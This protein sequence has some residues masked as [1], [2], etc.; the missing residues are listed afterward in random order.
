MENFNASTAVAVD[1]PLHPN[2]IGEL[3]EL[4]A[5]LGVIEGLIRSHIKLQESQ[6]RENI[7]SLFAGNTAL[8]TDKSSQWIGFTHKDIKFRLS[9]L[10][11]LL[12]TLEL[13]KEA[14]ARLQDSFPHY[15]RQ[16]PRYRIS[17]EGKTH[18]TEIHGVWKKIERALSI[19]PKIGPFSLFL[20]IECDKYMNELRSV[21]GNI[22]LRAHPDHP[23]SLEKQW[24]ERDVSQSFTSVS[25]QPEQLNIQDKEASL[26][27]E[28]GELGNQSFWRRWRWF[29]W[30]EIQL[31]FVC[32]L[33][34]IL[35]SVLKADPQTGFQI[36][37]FLFT[38]GTASL[39]A[40]RNHVKQR[41]KKEAKIRLQ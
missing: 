34:A 19:V 4:N 25:Q 14:F 1:F 32:L 37:A 28:S 6:S 2:F 15:W 23:F 21:I 31:I 12:E 38:I 40:F 10:K 29:L 35:Y 9:F 24:I 13:Y 20:N 5:T 22:S 3:S 8:L 17:L 36:A 39:T 18:L 27:V 33:F 30:K 16:D 41:E 26:D 11:G 7:D